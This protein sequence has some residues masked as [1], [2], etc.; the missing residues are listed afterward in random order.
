MISVDDAIKIIRSN[1][2]P[3][4]SEVVFV[5]DALGRVLFEDVGSRVSHPPMNVSSMDGYAVIFDNVRET[6]VTLTKIGTSQA[7]ISYKE[8]IKPGEAVRIF[9]GAIQK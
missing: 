9:T 3:C 7:G 1:I 4:G 6:P 2:T 8:K 5:E